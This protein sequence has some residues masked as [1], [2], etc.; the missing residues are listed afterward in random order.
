MELLVLLL[1]L[2]AVNAALWLGWG[3]DTRDNQNWDPA[4]PRSAQRRPHRLDPA[5]PDLTRRDSHV[6]PC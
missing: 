1:V 6:V 3:V 4:G 5:Q 2:L